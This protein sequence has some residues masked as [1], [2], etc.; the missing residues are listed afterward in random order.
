MIDA[1]IRELTP[2]PSAAVR[3]TQP[4]Q[5]LDIA[6]LF[7][8][9]LPNIA[10]RLADLGAEPAG[11]PYGRYHQFGPDVVDVEIGIPTSVP[12]ANLAS[13][14]DAQPGELAASE[15]P[16]GRVAITV[17]RGPY[18]GLPGVYDQLHDWIHAQGA[19][20]GPGP[21]ESYVDDPSVGKM[22]EVRTEVCWPIG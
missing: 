6:A 10:H 17:H 13:I 16:G 19:E 1:E 22:A 14:A 2:R 20:E 9:H 4:M 5:S 12:V 15:L 8:E 21:W 18:E 3:V 7:D 11:P